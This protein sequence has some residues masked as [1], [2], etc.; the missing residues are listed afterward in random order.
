MTICEIASSPLWRTEVF[1]KAQEN[2]W[3]ARSNTKAPKQVFHVQ[4]GLQY[5]E[6]KQ[7]ETPPVV[8]VFTC[9]YQFSQ[10]AGSLT[11]Q[12]LESLESLESLLLGP[13]CTVCSV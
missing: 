10:R 1:P 12:D 3:G 5:C 9:I 6:S 11:H 4:E 2:T 7:K 13:D 8:T